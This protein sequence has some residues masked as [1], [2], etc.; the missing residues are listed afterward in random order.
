MF[1]R[2]SIVLSF[3]VLASSSKCFI[4]LSQLFSVCL[5]K[6]AKLVLSQITQEKS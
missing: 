5:S 4:K 1:V 3:S 2:V 6:K